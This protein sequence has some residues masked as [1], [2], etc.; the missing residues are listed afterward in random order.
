MK[1][2]KRLI[3][4]LIVEDLR[5]FQV[6]ITIR[7]FKME[8]CYYHNYGMLIII[9]G[10]M[11]EEQKLDE[12]D[13]GGVYREHLYEVKYLPS[14]YFGENLRPLAKRCYHALRKRYE[15]VISRPNPRNRNIVE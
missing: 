7:D 8:N 5:R 14:T 4:D 10:I 11:D 1:N 12:Y 2:P 9:L 3:V 6:M 15:E 13:F